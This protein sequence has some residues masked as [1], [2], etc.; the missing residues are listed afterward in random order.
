MG[1]KFRN[2]FIVVLIICSFIGM[3]YYIYTT[4]SEIDI[5][6]EYEIKRTESTI[7][8]ETVENVEQQ[9][10]TI[11]DILE[12]VSQSVVGISRIKSHS[13]SI[14]SSKGSVDELGLG[15]GIIVSSNGYILSNC[16]VTGETLATCYV[17]LENGYTYKILL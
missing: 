17:T 9:S 11:A 12:N 8:A 7:P 10:Q 4:Y 16:H 6:P 15:T 14:F 13:N 5:T 3:S 1:K 2:F